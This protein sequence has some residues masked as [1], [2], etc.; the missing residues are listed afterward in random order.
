M[1]KGRQKRIMKE[2]RIRMSCERGRRRTRLTL[3]NAI[4]MIPVEYYEK[5]HAWKSPGNMYG[6]VGSVDEL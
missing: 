2:V 4:L 6:E 3:E 5:M 1:M